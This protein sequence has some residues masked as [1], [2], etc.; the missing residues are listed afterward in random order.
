MTVVTRFAP[1][2]TGFL[3][4]GGARTALFNW[5]FARH[6]GGVYRLRIEDTD[7]KRSTPEAI[8]AIKDG[9]TWLGIDHDDEI[10]FQSHNIQR[11]KDAVQQ[12]LELGHAYRCYCSSE[13]LMEMRKAARSE[14][15]SISYDRRWRDRDPADAP[16][17]ISPTIRIKM[18][19]KGETTIDD[20]VQ[21]PVT[22]QNSELDDFIL[23]RS[24][25]TPTYMH[26]VVVDDHDMGITHIVRGDDHLNN[27]F[28]QYHLYRAFGWDIPVFAHIPLIHG[29]DGQKL[30]KR[31]GALGVDAYRDMGY[32]PDAIRNYLL[33]L[34]WSHGDQ[35][36]IS[37]KQAIEWFD[38]DA[39]GKS[40][41]RFDF[42]R[43][44]NL[45]GH[46]IANMPDDIL[47]DLLAAAILK[48]IPDI[49]E[50]NL[51]NRA[52]QLLE[53]LKKRAKNLNELTENALF[54]AQRP[55]YPLENTKA[56]KFLNP[57]SVKLLEEM[58]G[59]LNEIM[60]WTLHSV[61]EKIRV[62]SEAQSLGL[63]NFTQPLR[64]ALTGSNAS[65][66]IFEILAALGKE[67]SL[68]RIAD[69]P[70]VNLSSR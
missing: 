42:D 3:H 59:A 49:D 11:H 47:I 16:H 14:G 43:L 46:Y 31:H 15:S 9:L 45:N 57:S 17:G 58:H 6:H 51:R 19:L 7:R 37:S 60:D 22:L 12:L 20:A 67:E 26:S 36:I 10:V 8:S 21:G 65:P 1:S 30:S 25:S 52:R 66:G 68:R 4:I 44:E 55:R 70:D 40:P 27:A 5:L 50:K 63:S 35:E 41:S 29:T 34:G 53:P 23:M 69:V 48:L 32:I 39:I 18:P 13:E 54:I 56:A 38:L 62:M 2:P 33:R 24:D 28:R 64:A 61:E